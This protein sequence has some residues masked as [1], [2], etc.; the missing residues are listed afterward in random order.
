MLSA[1]FVVGL[2]PR[3]PLAPASLSRSRP[4]VMESLASKMF[5]TLV[6]G[7][8][9]VAAAAGMDTE[10]A[11]AEAAGGAKRPSDIEGVVADI[12]AR[13]KTGELTFDDF[14]IMARG[15]AGIGESGGAL[16]GKLS[17]DQMLETR[18]KFERHASIV[19]V[20]LPEEKS[21]PALLID[22]LKA[23]AAKPGPRIQRLATA[24]GQPETEVALFLMQFEAMRESTR[25][26]AAGEDPD[27]VTESMSAA[28]GGSNRKARRAAKAKA[29]KKK[30]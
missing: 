15:F 3:A 26:I 20:M 22:D 6:D 8:K 5:G 25:R 18:A 16:P 12:D 19:D 27:A 10:E 1:L 29:K 14:V 21:D 24:S 2:A 28:P 30:M 4:V 13:A 11:P 17:T 7:V 9:G 23:G